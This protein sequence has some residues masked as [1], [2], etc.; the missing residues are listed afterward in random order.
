MRASFT[1]TVR[2]S[3]VRENSCD[4][5]VEYILVVVFNNY[6][7]FNIS[8]MFILSDFHLYTR[9]YHTK[10]EKINMPY[11]LGKSP[12]IISI[13]FICLFIPILFLSQE[14]I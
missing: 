11:K 2:F 9:I 10:G 1:N 13:Y 8:V 6:Y 4:I 3:N 14:L 5:S 7:R 12:N